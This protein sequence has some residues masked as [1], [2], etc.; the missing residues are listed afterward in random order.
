MTP[1]PFQMTRDEAITFLQEIKFNLDYLQAHYSQ[2]GLYSQDL[3]KVRIYLK[4]N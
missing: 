2:Q 1:L 3:T 4:L